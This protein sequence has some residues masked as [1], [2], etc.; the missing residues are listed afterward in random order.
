MNKYFSELEEKIIQ[1]LENALSN[2]DT[3]PNI[4]KNVSKD[5][6]QKSTILKSISRLE[7][8]EV[9]VPSKTGN[10]YFTGYN[11]RP[12]HT[13]HTVTLNKNNGDYIEYKKTLQ[14]K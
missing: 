10:L 4:V 3:K 1:H 8:R 2:T 14:R 7:I 13:P 11:V 12:Q 6:H 5:S 9:L